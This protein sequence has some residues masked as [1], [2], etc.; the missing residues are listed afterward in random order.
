VQGG[1]AERNMGA[2]R[3]KTPHHNAQTWEK[4]PVEKRISPSELK[5]RR[6]YA[7]GAGGKEKDKRVLYLKGSQIKP[8][9]P[10]CHSTGEVTEQEQRQGGAILS[11]EETIMRQITGQQKNKKWTRTRPSLCNKRGKRK[12]RY[13][14][15]RAD[16]SRPRLKLHHEMRGKIKNQAG[17]IG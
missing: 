12:E 13:E 17:M 4:E 14:T 9:H 5:C 8:L 15:L 3:T 11:V 2:R 6:S 16:E 10:S 7:S 1:Q